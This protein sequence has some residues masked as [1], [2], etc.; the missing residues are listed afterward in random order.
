VRRIFAQTSLNLKKGLIL[1]AIFKNQRTSSDFAKVFTYFNQISTYFCSDFHHV[2]TFEGT[3]SPPP[4]TPLK[5]RNL[6]RYIRC[7]SY[8]G[9]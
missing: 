1:S 4:P 9:E 6:C 2:K 8:I 7:T 5:A 3:L